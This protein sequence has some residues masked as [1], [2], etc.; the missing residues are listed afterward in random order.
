MRNEQQ[1][2]DPANTIGVVRIPERMLVRHMQAALFI[3]RDITLGVAHGQSAFSN[4]DVAYRGSSD[5]AALNRGVA[6]FAADATAVAALQADGEP[7]CG[8]TVPVVP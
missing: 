5:D 2:Q 1:K 6:R 3:F 8:L 7:T 4:L